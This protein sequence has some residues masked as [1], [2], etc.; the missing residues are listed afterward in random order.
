MLSQKIWRDLDLHCVE[1]FKAHEDAV[2]ALAVVN[3][4]TMYTGLTN[5]QIWVWSKPFR[6]DR[7]GVGSGLGGSS[8]KFRAGWDLGWV[9]LVLSLG[10]IE[11]REER[12]KGMKVG[13]DGWEGF[14]GC[15]WVSREREERE[16]EREREIVV[17]EG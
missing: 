7:S 14:E 6:E 2:N 8:F 10:K 12:V 9:V 17:E 5:C 1:S 13:G 4:G 3:D 16:K 15:R 11:Q